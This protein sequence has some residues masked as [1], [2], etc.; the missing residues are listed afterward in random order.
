MGTRVGGKENSLGKLAE[1]NK[2]ERKGG[3]GFKELNLLNIVLL[4]KQCWKIIEN[5]AMSVKVIK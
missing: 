2:E 3:M 5:Q 4:I 1:F